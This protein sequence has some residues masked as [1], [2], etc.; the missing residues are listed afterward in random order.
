MG[1]F[2]RSVSKKKPAGSGLIASGSRPGGSTR[3]GLPMLPGSLS[4]GLKNY[5][6]LVGPKPGRRGG[7][8]QGGRKG[9]YPQG[10]PQVFHMRF[11]GFLQHLTA[12]SAYERRVARDRKELLKRVDRL[13]TLCDSLADGQEHLKA[14]L[15]KLG[16][17]LGGALGGRP[18]K[19]AVAPQEEPQTLSDIPPGDKAALRRWFSQRGT[20]L[21]TDEPQLP[22]EESDR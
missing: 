14:R 19:G 17:R 8:V 12:R 10:Y 18:T 3:G 11:L 9:D 15:A 2:L 6:G 20:T 1:P 16:T 13:E 22:L 21:K 7:C 4:T 5:K